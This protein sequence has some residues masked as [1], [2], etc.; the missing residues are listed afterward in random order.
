MNRLEKERE[1]QEQQEKEAQGKLF[2]GDFLKDNRDKND[3]GK[4]MP[5]PVTPSLGINGAKI[6]EVNG[7]Q[8]EMK[9]ENTGSNGNNEDPDTEA[10]P[11]NGF[12]QTVQHAKEQRSPFLPQPPDEQSSPDF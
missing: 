7:G 3:A 12:G 2:S 8:Q 9:N 1:A 11:L 4:D 10:V 6:R 5:S